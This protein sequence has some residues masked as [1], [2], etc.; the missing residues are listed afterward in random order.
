MKDNVLGENLW[1]YRKAQ[2]L[3]QHEL[4]KELYVSAHSLSNYETGT[5]DPS[6][7]MLV[8]LAKLLKTDPN[9][10]LGWKENTE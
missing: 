7:D 6:M 2:G 3:K 5:C 10:L 4:A 8:K 1:K 9:T